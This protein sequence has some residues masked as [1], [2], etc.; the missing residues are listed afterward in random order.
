MWK[1][2]EVVVSD[3]RAR[4]NLKEGDSIK[5]MVVRIPTHRDGQDSEVLAFMLSPEADVKIPIFRPVPRALNVQMENVF[6]ECRGNELFYVDK[7][8]LEALFKPM[9]AAAGPNGVLRQA[10]AVGD[11]N[12]T[13]DPMSVSL[14]VMRLNPRAGVHGQAIAD[15]AKPT[16]QYQEILKQLD[17][18]KF[19][20]SFIH[21]EDSAEVLQRAQQIA[22]AAGFTTVAN[23]KPL[24]KD[25][26]IMFGK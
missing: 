22:E 6:F 14:G 23:P 13:I 24:P 12:Y 25:N 20:I 10:N 7:N 2:Q 9:Q 21:R 4:S 8:G 15:L 16:G 26:P 5:F 3:M 19:T 18:K 11:A 1:D 17:P